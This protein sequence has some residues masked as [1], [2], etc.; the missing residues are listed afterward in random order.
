MKEELRIDFFQKSDEPCVGSEFYS[1]PSSHRAGGEWN[2]APT[3]RKG[4]SR[5]DKSV[6]EEKE[7]RNQ[8]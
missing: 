2:S 4:K 6:V 7:I 3:D 8:E 1:E 5:V